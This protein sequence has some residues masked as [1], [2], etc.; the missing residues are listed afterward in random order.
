MMYIFK[1]FYAMQYI[2]MML[3]NILLL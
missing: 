2:Y 1:Q 3:H